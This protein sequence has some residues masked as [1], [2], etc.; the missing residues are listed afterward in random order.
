MTSI[1]WLVEQLKN[2]NGIDI[3]RLAATDRAKE[4]HRQEII[5]AWDDGIDSFSTRSAEQYY[6]ETFKKD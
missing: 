3:E 4:M 2:I 5:D 6:N 1:E